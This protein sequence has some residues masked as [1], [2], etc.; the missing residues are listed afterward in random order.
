MSEEP[1]TLDDLGGGIRTL[2]I[3]GGNGRWVSLKATG[4]ITISGCQFVN[5]TGRSIIWF[6]IKEAIIEV[7]RYPLGRV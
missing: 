5:Q 4:D 1:L 6:L 2:L 7:V 3:R